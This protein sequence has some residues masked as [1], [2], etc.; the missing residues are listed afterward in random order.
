MK[1]KSRAINILSHMSKRFGAELSCEQLIHK[2]DQKVDRRNNCDGEILSKK[3]E[4]TRSEIAIII[5]SAREEKGMSR[6]Q[7]ALQ[8]GVTVDFLR[9]LEGGK[10]TASSLDAQMLFRV[11]NELQ[12]HPEEVLFTKNSRFG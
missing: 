11:T 5:R 4:T 7:L 8:A 9:G 10:K 3:R 6:A 2:T 12:M 1:A